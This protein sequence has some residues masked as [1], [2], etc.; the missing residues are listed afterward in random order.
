MSSYRQS[1][2]ISPAVRIV[3][4]I[5]ENKFCF[6]EE[7]VVSIPDVYGCKYVKT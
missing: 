2:V 7:L 4:E 3:S 6:A 5:V 1:F